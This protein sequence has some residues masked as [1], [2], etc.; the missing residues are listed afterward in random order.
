[1]Y[2]ETLK[3]SKTSF[4]NSVL[5]IFLLIVGL[6]VFMGILNFL[7]RYIGI[8]FLSYIYLAFVVY[9]GWY[10]INKIIVEFRYTLIENDLIFEKQIGNNPK[11]VL[12]INLKDVKMIAPVKSHKHIKDNAKK[13]FKL[14]PS[15]RSQK[16]Y[17]GI[18]KH[19]GVESKFIFEPT[20]Q[21][22]KLLKRQ[23]PNKVE[24]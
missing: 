7:N 4:F 2:R 6:M 18:F 9:L 16:A 10:I 5:F 15:P 11:R 3:Q 24:N 1:M 23:I 22:V 12:T 17:F 19:D 8:P 13:I 21:M 20:D 14:T